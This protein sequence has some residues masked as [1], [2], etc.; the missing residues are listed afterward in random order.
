MYNIILTGGSGF[1]GSFIIRE[2]IGE[3]SPIPVNRLIILD[4]KPLDIRFDDSRIMF[5]QGDVRDRDLLIQVCK[6]MDLVI[7]SAAIVDWG[8]K[9]NEEVMEVNHGGTLNI[10]E[11]C[12]VNH[13]KALVYT[14]SLDVLF[15]GEPLV[16]VDENK[17]YPKKFSTSYCESKYLA[18]LSVIEANSPGL[19]T[20]SLRPSDIYGERD[21]YHLGPLIA[22][23][24]N[25]FYVRLGKGTAK[26]QHV[27]AGNAAHAHL[28]AAGALLDGN[29]EIKGQSY[30]ITD[31]P[32]TNFFTFFDRIVE[33][34]GYRIRPKNLW[35]PR[36][37]AF[38]LGVISEFIA[39]LIR[40]LKHYTP[41]M[42]RFAV[43]YTCT[44]YT[45]TS[46]KAGKDFNFVPKYSNE[47]AF[48]RTVRFFKKQKL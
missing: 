19:S 41:K 5:V 21:P 37:F 1:L 35:L 48:D 7:H 13:V 43:T 10:L 9:S 16:N 42:S 39:F 23:A 15:N 36:W 29:P 3:S 47:E 45:F 12:R 28:L 40:P 17:P 8:T 32:G 33:A 30:F 6:D 46:E 34:A 24:G 22:M 2:L 26:C 27:Y 31:A 25:G 44:D 14:S 20:C 11:A 4:L 18:E 38:S